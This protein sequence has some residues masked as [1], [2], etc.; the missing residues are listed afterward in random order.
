MPG[1]WYATSLSTIA[2]SPLINLAL[3]GNS[4][5]VRIFD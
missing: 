1:D 5:S 3:G 4:F 2:T